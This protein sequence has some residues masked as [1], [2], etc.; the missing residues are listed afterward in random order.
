MQG[1]PCPSSTGRVKGNWL[2]GRAVSVQGIPP[3]TARA[4]AV[5]KGSKLPQFLF[6]LDVRRRMGTHSYARPSR[7]LQAT[8]QPHVSGLASWSKLIRRPLQGGAGCTRVHVAIAAPVLR[9]HFWSSPSEHRF[10]CISAPCSCSSMWQQVLEGELRA[11]REPYGAGFFSH[12]G[13]REAARRILR[14]RGD[15]KVWGGVEWSRV[16]FGA[17]STVALGGL[18]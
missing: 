16:S 12:M 10:D 17:G 13:H 4:M 1:C 15:Q 14:G 11:V 18:G 3:T 9:Q 6:L 5:D 7:S 8:A 2:W